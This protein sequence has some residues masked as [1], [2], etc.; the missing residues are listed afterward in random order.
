ML[1]RLSDFYRIVSP[2]PADQTI[3]QRRASIT[4]LQKALSDPKL[5]AG[6]AELAAFGLGAN[7]NGS[8]SAVAEQ[9]VKAIQA[10]HPAFP[11]ELSAHPL[12]LRVCAG[13]AL[14]EYIKKNEATSASA[15]VVTALATR[16]PPEERHLA[17]FLSALLST[18]RGKLETR[19]RQSRQRP[20]LPKSAIV[21]AEP[22]AFAK[23]VSDAFEALRTS[24]EANLKADREELQV[25]WW[26]FGGASE[27]LD[28]NYRL[29]EP[30]T[31]VLASALELS[32]L[33]VV[34][35]LSSC[36]HFLLKIIQDDASLG[37]QALV[38]DC[39]AEILERFEQADPVD[40]VLK[41]HPALL[42]MTWL[43]TRQADSEMAPGWETEF[44][45]KTHL[46]RN[47]TRLAS[48]WAA[49]LFNER[50]AARVLTE[51]DD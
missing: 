50:I 51:E 4:D 34:P 47:E 19:A 15:L 39:P 43:F 5:Q 41:H 45:R 27:I 11:S 1:D 40:H 22:A 44:E 35:A 23:T 31:R 48:R 18:A 38:E 17:T 32:Q 42:P 21:E 13:V 36:E 9:L 10:R 30:P 28:Q 25:L 26:V 24:L 33:V 2:E 16:Q 12:D 7:P 14:G 8:Q 20:S 3:T 49:Q 37:L 6:C 46:A 29:L